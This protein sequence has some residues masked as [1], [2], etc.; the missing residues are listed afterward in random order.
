MAPATAAGTAGGRA[1]ARNPESGIWNLLLRDT[2]TGTVVHEHKVRSGI[3]PAWRTLSGFPSVTSFAFL[4]PVVLLYWQVGGPSALLTDPNT[5]VHVRAGEWILGHHAIPRQDVF[6]FTLDGRPWCDWEWLS[7]VLY[8]LL[9]RLRGLSAIVAFHLTLLCV[10]SVILYRTA[11]LRVGPTMAFAVTCLVMATTTIHWLARPHLF[12]WLF[13]AVFCFL[14]ERADVTGEYRPLP[15][16]PALTILWVNLHPGFVAGLLVLAAWSVSALLRWRL[17]GDS[18]RRARWGNEAL[19]F[20]LT[21]ATCLAATCVTPYFW[22]LDSHIVTYLFS[23]SSMTAH[24]AEWFPPDFHNPRLHWFELLLPVVAAS[25][26]RQGLRGHLAHCAII[27]GSMHLALGSVRNVPL[28]AIVAVGP[29]AATIGPLLTRSSFGVQLGLGEDALGL[30]GSRALTVASYMLG[31]A[32]LLGV[33]WRGPVSFGPASSLPID[34]ARHLPAGRLF[35]TDQWA[36]YLIYTQPRRQVFFDC[37]N[38]AYG[39]EV[40]E[41]YIT[42]MTAAPGWGSVLDRH[43]L[44]VALVP[45]TSAITAALSE[46]RDWK[47]FYEEPVAAVFTRSME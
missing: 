27:L 22:R 32:V 2:M 30:R 28:F 26:L 8:V 41:D 4:L 20:Y 35:T 31:F 33:L 34:A 36:D 13:L 18:E 45:K 5:G 24:V 10:I 39:D 46:S 1:D 44:S 6:S 37:R 29:L 42:V 16:L 40:V 38:D 19:W 25:A 12:T 21:L 17:A 43:S 23:S 11:R 14:L 7:D 9:F 15:A 3:E 47:L